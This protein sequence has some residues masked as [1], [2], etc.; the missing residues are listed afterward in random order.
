M[1]FSSSSTALLVKSMSDPFAVLRGGARF[2]NKPAPKRI[3]ASG[4]GAGA[5]VST[6]LDFFGDGAAAAGALDGTATR[7]R[8]GDEKHDGKR[9]RKVRS[10]P[11][12]FR[13]HFAIAR[14]DAQCWCELA[15]SQSFVVS[16]VRGHNGLSS[17]KLSTSQPRSLLWAHRTHPL[18]HVIRRPLKQTMRLMSPICSLGTTLAFTA[19]AAASTSR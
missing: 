5:A 12:I 8:G 10:I 1:H 14:G 18:T 3:G 7:K 17:I 19:R 9:R 4:G 2:K 11:C 15:S 13:E 6:A 16:I